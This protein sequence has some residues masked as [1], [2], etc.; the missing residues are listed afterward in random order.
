MFL[1]CVLAHKNK[2]VI[3]NTE[4]NKGKLKL[5]MKVKDFPK[6]EKLITLKFNVFELNETVLSPALFD[7]PY[8][9]KQINLLLYENNYGLIT[10]IHT[11]MIKDSAMTYV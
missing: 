1:W 8:S 7:E 9:E 3:V 10:K 6:F 4:L 11:L 2:L 5:S